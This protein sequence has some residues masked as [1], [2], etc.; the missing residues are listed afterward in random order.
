LHTCA[1]GKKYELVTFPTTESIELDVVC[2]V[3]PATTTFPAVVGAASVHAVPEDPEVWL[4]IVCEPG[5]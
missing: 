3:S 1:Y 4:H 5:T 2:H